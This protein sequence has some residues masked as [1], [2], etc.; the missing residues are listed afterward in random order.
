MPNIS[1]FII[2]IWCGD[3]SKPT[4]LDEYLMA[5]VTELKQLLENPI[6]ISNHRIHVRVRCFVCDTPARAF[7]K[8]IAF[9][10]IYVQ[11]MKNM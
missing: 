10:C 7:I 11:H 4:D 2:A 3:M 9:T 5:F 6:R 1:P 8:G